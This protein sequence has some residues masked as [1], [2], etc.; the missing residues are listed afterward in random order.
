[1]QRWR[2]RQAGC[3]WLLA[4]AVAVAGQATLPVSGP[5]YWLDVSDPARVTYDAQTGE[6][7][8]LSDKSGNGYDFERR[9]THYSGSGPFYGPDY[10]QTSS[11]NSPPSGLPY[12]RFSPLTNFL[13][14]ATARTT[15]PRTIFIVHQT[16]GTYG[17]GGMWGMW[18][19]KGPIGDYNDR[20]MRAGGG[21]NT[22]TWIYDPV[23][24]TRDFGWTY[25]LE[26]IY[27]TDSS[28]FDRRQTSFTGE[29][30]VT[31]AYGTHD[32]PQT[33]LAVY[34]ET[35]WWGGGMGEVIV[36]GRILTDDERQAVERYLKLKWLTPRGGL[37][38]K[39]R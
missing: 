10:V 9:R 30:G 14:Q 26:D 29:W 4:A 33:S 23:W 2:M 20:G 35:R 32:Y 15:S 24:K 11:P 37:V 31:A 16:T 17:L 22:W 34:Y 27:W 21:G 6:I 8:T 28:L 18:G 38:L 3:V 39:V 12:A 25:E 13:V 5:L 19:W 7:L 1:M 36:Y